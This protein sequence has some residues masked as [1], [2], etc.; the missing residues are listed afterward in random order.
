MAISV[1]PE[2]RRWPFSHLDTTRSEVPNRFASSFCVMRA[3]S[4]SFFSSA[5]R[6]AA[7]AYHAAEA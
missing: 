1:S 2:I 6:T 4:R 7:A 3:A 5:A